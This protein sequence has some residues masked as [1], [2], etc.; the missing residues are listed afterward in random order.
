MVV[1][2]QTAEDERLVLTEVCRRLARQLRAANVAFVAATGTPRTVVSSVGARVELSIVERVVS[3]SIV[4]ARL[5]LH[6]SVAG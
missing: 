6:D 5:Q 2:R 3:A 1:W 4:V